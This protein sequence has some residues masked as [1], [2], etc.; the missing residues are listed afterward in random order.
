MHTLQTSYI[1][2]T[3]RTQITID[4]FIKHDEE[5]FHAYLSKAYFSSLFF[6]SFEVLY[7]IVHFSI[8]WFGYG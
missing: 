8:L 1:K 5:A 3:V 2:F 7:A 6:C 4:H